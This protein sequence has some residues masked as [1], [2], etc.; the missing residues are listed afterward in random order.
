MSTY[1]TINRTILAKVE[2]TAGTDPSPVVG[3]DALLIEAPQSPSNLEVL[4]TDEVTGTLDPDDP[5]VGGGGGGFSGTVNVRGSGSAGTAPEAGPL[6]QGCG[7]AETLLAADVTGTAVSPFAAGTIEVAAGDGSAAGTAIGHLIITTG[8]TGS[9]QTRVIT[10]VN[11]DDLDIFPDWTTTPDATTTY[12]IKASAIYV[13]ASTGLK[14]ITIYDYQHENTAAVNSRLRSKTGCMGNVNFTLPVR[15][16]VKAAFDFQGKFVTPTDVAKP[17]AATFD[18]QRPI[19]F[20]AA[21][22]SLGGTTTKI[23]QMTVDLGN[24]VQVADDPAD[25]FGVDFASIVKRNITG[26]INPPMALLSARNVWADFLAGTTRKLW[27]S[28][29]TVNG[30]RVSFYFPAIQYTGE[31]QEDINGFAHEG[32]PFAATGQDTGCYIN[33]A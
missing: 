13:P 1:R 24:D 27:V 10:N 12:A 30:N 20:Q 4:T 7:L 3:T 23:N 9:G 29:G 16:L 14:N 22:I 21:T 33:I 2:V 32:I 5:V 6:Y 18:T 25:T 31:E 19:A 11:T 8:G 26:K 17:A 28:Y 15:G